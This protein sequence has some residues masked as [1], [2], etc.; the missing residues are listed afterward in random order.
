MIEYSRSSRE[1]SGKVLSC[2]PLLL[3]RFWKAAFC[4]VSIGWNVKSH[5]AWR[6]PLIIPPPKTKHLSMYM[7]SPTPPNIYMALCLV[8]HADILIALQLSLL[9]LNM[10]I[11][12]LRENSHL[13]EVKIPRAG[14]VRFAESS[15]RQQYPCVTLACP[16]AN[17]VFGVSAVLTT[18]HPGCPHTDS[19]INYASISYLHQ[20]RDNTAVRASANT[21]NIRQVLIAVAI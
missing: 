13:L 2:F 9:Q 19:E 3:D 8:N 14:T 21:M 18:A 4:P 11:Y 5:E 10:V 7:Y 12:V 17:P 20:P 1:C 16:V 15:Q 6:W